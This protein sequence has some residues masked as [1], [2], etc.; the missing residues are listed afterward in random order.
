MFKRFPL[1][2]RF[3]VSGNSSSVVVLFVCL[4]GWLVGWVGRLVDRFFYPCVHL[5]GLW[6][7]DLS[8]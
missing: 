6:Q 2:V 5:F 8:V 4:F 3:L 1:V 7:F